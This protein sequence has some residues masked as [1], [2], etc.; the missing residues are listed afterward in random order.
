VDIGQLIFLILAM[1]LLAFTLGAA[2]AWRLEGRRPLIAPIWLIVARNLSF[3]AWTMYIALT[4]DLPSRIIA[5]D[6]PWWNTIKTLLIVSAI[7]ALP[8]EL[9]SALRGRRRERA[10]GSRW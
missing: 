2:V 3:I 7:V 10:G 5:I 1:V 6:P 9:R 4:V 8:I